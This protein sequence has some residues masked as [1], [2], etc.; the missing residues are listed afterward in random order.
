MKRPYLPFVSGVCILAC[1]IFTL[2]CSSSNSSNSKN[3]NSGGSASSGLQF[4]SPASAPSIDAGQ[5]VTLTVNQPVTWTLEGNPKPI[6]TL[7]SET[8][9]SVTY[10]S[11]ATISGAAQD[12]VLATS[13]ADTTQSAAIPVVVNP[14]LAVNGVFGGANGLSQS[15]VYDPV[16]GVGGYN[17]Q[18]GVTYG[19]QA[20]GPGPGRTGTGPYTIALGS[21]TLPPGLSLGTGTGQFGGGP[22]AYLYGSPTSPGCYQLTVT[23]TDA[24]GATATSATNYV[25][26]APAPLKVQLPN[27]PDTYSGLPYQ[28]T[29]ITASGGV[30]PYV[31][32]NA[33]ITN[34]PPGLTLTP[35][36][37][38]S[39][40]AV[41]SGTI[42][43]GAGTNG[44]SFT[45]TISVYDSQQPY[46][47]QGSATL[48]LF[49]WPGLPANACQPSQ[50]STNPEFQTNLSNLHGTYAF[51]MRGFDSNGPVVMAGSF[52]ADGAGNVNTNGVM[53]VM[54]T[55]GSQVGVPITG[56]SYVLVNSSPSGSNTGLSQSGCLT[57]TNQTTS[58]TFA[59]SMGGCSTSSN[60]VDAT[61]A[62]DMQ[63]QPGIYTTGRL[64]EFDNATGAGTRGSGIIR[65]QDSNSFSSGMNGMY[66]FG[67]SGWDSN[68]ANATQGRYA[69]AGSFNASSGTLSSIAADINDGGTLQSAITSGSGGFGSVDPSTGR[70]SGALTA[71]SASLSSLVAYIV[72]SR[73]VIV[74]DTGTPSPSN[75]FVAGEA[76]S[77]SG[78]FSVA[79]VQNRHMFHAA[80]LAATGPDV[81]IGTLQFDGFGGFSISQYEDQAGTLG[82]ESL[83]GNYAVDQNSGRLVFSGSNSNQNLG[84][85]PLVGYVV[86]APNTLTR[87]ACT[88]LSRCVTG[89]LISS[90]ATAQAGLLE[91]QTPTY[92]PPPPFSIDFVAGDYFYGTDETLSPQAT[93]FVG[94]SFATPN[95]SSYNAIQSASYSSFGYCQQPSCILLIPNETLTRSSK[96]SVNSDGTGNI[97]GNTI[98]VTNGNVTFYL[99]ESPLDLTPTVIVVEQ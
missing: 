15:C 55:S 62:N 16:H 72:S 36:P 35:S 24:T 48:N 91:F 32:W 56:G 31:G 20:S 69:A 84:N 76:I 52:D 11:P 57:L 81:S 39:A 93:E 92:G 64:I 80:G 85:H 1:L 98:A 95:N 2:A 59:V 14:A 87:Q 21:G 97:G 74:V 37:T 67:L 63:G 50:I 82:S 3:G 99:D 23:V 83:S 30:P 96:Y 26:I 68:N 70:A 19:S 61:C 45:S 8:T 40:S 25:I 54:R 65:L 29:A 79:A 13:T 75:P 5:S 73:E 49:Q 34:M 10:T 51:L 53:D 78:P 94:A 42:G 4:T 12:T 66:A 71:G 33:D 38:D 9:T 88:T 22:F 47:A 90:D 77:T 86:A 58:V 89:F 28:P 17:D 27:Y 46:P 44:N 18:V 6:G 41:L 60:P 7:T 43:G